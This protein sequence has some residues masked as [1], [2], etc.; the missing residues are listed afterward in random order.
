MPIRCIAVSIFHFKISIFRYRYY[1]SSIPRISIFLRRYIEICVGLLLEAYSFTEKREWPP[2]CPRGRIRYFR[3]SVKLQA[4]GCYQATR[5]PRR[6]R[7]VNC[8]VTLASRQSEWLVS[9]ILPIS[10]LRGNMLSPL[11]LWGSLQAT[12]RLARFA[13]RF[14]LAWPNIND[15]TFGN[16]QR[17]IETVKTSGNQPET[18]P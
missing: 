16:N 13:N 2:F 6:E 1:C 15:R 8:Y 11:F 18:L 5:E 4:S 9:C 12:S 17:H 10:A 3:F 7:G 14:A